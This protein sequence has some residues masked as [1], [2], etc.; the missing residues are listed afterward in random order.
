MSLAGGEVGPDAA[1]STDQEIELTDDDGRTVATVHASSEPGR[2]GDAHD[3][4][5]V[6]VV[7]ERPETPL[8]ELT[9][10]LHPEAVGVAPNT[11]M[12]QPPGGRWPAFEFGQS[13]GRLEL[14]VRGL[15]TPS[16]QKVEFWVPAWAL[17]AG[18]AEGPDGQGPSDDPGSRD[19]DRLPVEVEVRLGDDGVLSRGQEGRAGFQLP[20]GQAGR[21]EGG[22]A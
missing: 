18:V 15:D 10:R 9:V 8:Q 21:A 11:V 3:G 1:G 6:R 20:F 16:T 17:E 4:R 5:S 19:G 7:V 13:D 12:L 2:G 22:L 14:R